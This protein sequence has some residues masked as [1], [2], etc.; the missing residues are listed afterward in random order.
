MFREALA[1]LEKIVY[2]P[3][4]LNIE[5]I[6]EEKQNSNYGA[7][8]FKLASRTVR[9]RVAKK[10]PTKI[11]Q[12]VGFWEKVQNNKK[13]PFSYEEAPDLLVITTSMMDDH[14]GQFIFRKKFL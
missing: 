13:Q 6:Q 9:F 12:F 10:T 3:N 1:Y 8:T 5:F 2:E 14:F 11:G 7:G 4:Q